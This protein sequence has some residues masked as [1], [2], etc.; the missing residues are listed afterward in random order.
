MWKR[1]R[2]W[3]HGPLIILYGHE[4]VSRFH[5][6]Y[7]LDRSFFRR[8]RTDGVGTATSSQSHQN[9]LDTV[10][11]TRKILESS[12]YS[13]F[14]FLSS[15]FSLL[16]VSNIHLTNIR[17]L[18]NI[19]F[20][21]IFNLYSCFIYFNQFSMLSIYARNSFRINFVSSRC[22][23]AFDSHCIY[24]RETSYIVKVIYSCNHS[25]QLN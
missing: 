3:T 20:I 18:Y 8:N 9:R 19:E 6:C 4:D 11:S 16:C 7:S 2:R 14:L 23:L 21:F 10:N 17:Y 12:T 5:G 22:I 1:S 25:K 13:S 15:L 24:N